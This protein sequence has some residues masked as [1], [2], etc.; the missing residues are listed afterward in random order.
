MRYLTASTLLRVA[1]VVI[2]FV[3]LL[4]YGVGNGWAALREGSGG[5]E[6]PRGQLPE[7]LGTGAALTI[8]C[9]AVLASVLFSAPARLAK[10]FPQWSKDDWSAHVEYLLACPHPG[11]TPV[12]LA[13]M[14]L[15]LGRHYFDTDEPTARKHYAAAIALVSEE[16]DL[17]C[18]MGDQILQDGQVDLAASVYRRVLESG[19]RPS[20]GAGKAATIAESLG[21]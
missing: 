18:T 15:S 19:P 20:A 2:A 12:G 3:S 14:H 13:S 1:P 5:V 6:P 21:P 8:S 9:G 7:L 10:P 17:L 4:L 16:P 11:L